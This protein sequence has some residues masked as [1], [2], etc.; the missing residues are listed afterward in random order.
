MSFINVM[1]FITV[2][3]VLQKSFEEADLMLK[4]DLLLL[5]VL[6]TVMLLNVFFQDSLMNI[7]FKRTSKIDIF[8]VYT[9]TFHQFNES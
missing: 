4:T 5:S 3:C 8:V 9:V 6:K 7:K 1:T 2:F